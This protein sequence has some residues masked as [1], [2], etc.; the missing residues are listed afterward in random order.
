MICD[1]NPV[2]HLAPI[3]IQRQKSLFDRVR[4]EQWDEFFRVLV[5]AVVITAAGDQRREPIGVSIARTVRSAAALL[6]A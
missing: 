2:P 3:A 4:D 5:R 6:A 1:V